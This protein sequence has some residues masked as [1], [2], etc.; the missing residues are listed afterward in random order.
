MPQDDLEG[1]MAAFGAKNA[2]EGVLGPEFCHS[3]ACW[4][5]HLKHLA[6]HEARGQGIFAISADACLRF[7]D[8]LP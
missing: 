4:E 5:A 6:S 3:E 1:V 8:L 7:G 2:S